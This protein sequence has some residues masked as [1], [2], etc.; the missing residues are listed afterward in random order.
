MNAFKSTGKI[1]ANLRTEIG[2]EIV[3]NKIWWTRESKVIISI[4]QAWNF[5]LGSLP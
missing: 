5:S 1:N 4:V 2:F 3:N